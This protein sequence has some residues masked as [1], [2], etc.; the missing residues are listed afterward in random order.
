M[1]DLINLSVV[2]V[3]NLLSISMAQ[4]LGWWII[5]CCQYAGIS[6]NPS[7]EKIKKKFFIYVYIYI[8]VCMSVGLNSYLKMTR[9][10]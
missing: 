5:Q 9:C 2:K 1:G 4:W 10:L 3:P 6:S 8:H 7:G